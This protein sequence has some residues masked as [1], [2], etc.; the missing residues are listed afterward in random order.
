MY[1]DCA[2]SHHFSR[3]MCKSFLLVIKCLLKRITVL[4]FVVKGATALYII[5]RVPNQNDVSQ[6]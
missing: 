1:P 6:A 3:L 2:N 4:R 5:S